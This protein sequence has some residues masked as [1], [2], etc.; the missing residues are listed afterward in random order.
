MLMLRMLLHLLLVRSVKHVLNP[1]RDL[2]FQSQ[3]DGPQ[4]TGNAGTLGYAE[5]EHDDT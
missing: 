2:S 3:C 1:T 4:V 5:M